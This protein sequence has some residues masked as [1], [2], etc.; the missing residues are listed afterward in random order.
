MAED[1]NDKIEKSEDRKATINQFQ[2][3]KSEDRKASINQFQQR[4]LT[5]L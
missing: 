1:V 2:I 3:E 4:K 5:K